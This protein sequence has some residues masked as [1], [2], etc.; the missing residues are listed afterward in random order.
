MRLSPA[1]RERASNEAPK[2]AETDCRSLLPELR[3]RLHFEQGLDADNG[4]RLKEMAAFLFFLL[5][6][7]NSWGH[8]SRSLYTQLVWVDGKAPL[9]IPHVW[10][11]QPGFTPASMIP[12]AARALKGGFEAKGFA[13]LDGNTV[14]ELDL[15][16]SP[17]EF[18]FRVLPRGQL[19]YGP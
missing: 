11:F 8:Y 4:V 15:F 3:A 13:L 6:D 1:E 14:V 5:A 17:T 19:P 7:H 16:I 2:L 9:P 10:M 12:Y 18:S